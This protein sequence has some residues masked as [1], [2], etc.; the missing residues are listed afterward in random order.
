MFILRSIRRL[1]QTAGVLLLFAAPLF[2]QP[3][4]QAD[5]PLTELKAAPAWQAALAKPVLAPGQPMEEVMAFCEGQVPLVAPP[6]DV[7]H[8][9][10]YIQGVRRDVLALVFRGEAARWRDAKCGVVWGDT[11]DGGEGYRLKKLRYEALPGLWIPAILYEPLEIQGR[12]PVVLNVNGHDRT[13]KAA[14]YKQTRCINLAKRGILALNVEWV[15]MG[16]LATPGFKHYAMNQ[17]DLCGTSGLAV[18]YLAMTRGIDLLLEHP[19]ADPE[20]VGVA[21]LSG[22]GWQTI[23]VSSLDPRV[24]LSNPVAGYS[25]YKTRARIHSDLGDSEQ[26]PSDLASVADYT[27][28]TAMRAPRPTLLTFNAKDN[29]CF[30]SGHALEPLLTAALPIYKLYG[31]E[32][33]LETHI[34]FDPGNHNFG[35][36]NREAFYAIVGRHF[37]PGQKDYSAIEIECAG[38]LKT[39]MELA[40]ELPAQNTD[41]HA[42]ALEI[43]GRLPAATA[44]AGDAKQL[45][46]WSQSERTRLV[47]FLRLRGP[48]ARSNAAFEE[49]AGNVHVSGMRFRFENGFTVPVIELRPEQATSTPPSKG[50]SHSK[51]TTI[52]IADEGRT[53]ATAAIERALAAGER[54]VAIDPFYFGESKIGKRDFLLAMLIACLGQRP[55]GIQAEQVATIAGSLRGEGPLRLV[56]HGPRSGVIALCAA[57]LEPRIESIEIEGGLGTLRE[58]LEQDRSVDQWPEMFAFGMLAEFDI[59]TL[60]MS[61]APRRIQFTGLSEAG[62][63]ALAALPEHYRRHSVEFDPRIQASPGQTK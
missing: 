4:A 27:H 39:A 14:D 18:Y 58:V 29:C 37:F 34:N 51:G 24:T 63:K 54:V 32:T 26:T 48:Q 33:R 19:A 9:E 21:G 40:V 1:T 41:F 11:I 49:T 20:R 23:F 42:L 8:W 43:S 62:H 31:K 5:T 46:E 55:L 61:I 60:A 38:E 10:A 7:A 45:A 16:Q 25:S 30:A 2:A 47:Q 35:K 50:T 28:L 13:G 3:A 52:V 17:L 56:A 6:K 53:A 44:P 59:P 22:G 15:G 36:E 12:V 57:V